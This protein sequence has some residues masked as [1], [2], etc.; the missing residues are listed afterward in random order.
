MR[1]CRNIVKRPEGFDGSQLNCAVCGYYEFVEGRYYKWVGNPHPPTGGP[2][3]A[4]PEPSEVTVR[5]ARDERI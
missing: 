3:V 5:R 1:T 2:C 4:G